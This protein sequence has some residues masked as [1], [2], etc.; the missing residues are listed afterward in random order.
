LTLARRRTLAGL[1]FVAPSTILIVVFFLIPVAMTAW[2]SLHDWPL[3]GAQEWLGLANYIDLLGDPVF[4]SAL[5]FTATYALMVTPLTLVVG[6]GLAQIVRQ[7]LGGMGLLRT[8]YFVPV[9]IGFAAASFIWY[10][11]LDPR[12]GILDAFLRGI[13]LTDGPTRF[14]GEPGTALGAAAVLF[15]WKFAGF[16]MLIFL[17]G[18]QAIPT[19]LY[20]A[21]A[22]DGASARQR[23]RFVTIPLLRRTFALVLVVTLIAALLAFDQ[24][25]VLTRGGPQDET[26]TVVYWIYKSGFQYMKLGYGS[27]IAVVLLL[28]LALMSV[29]QLVALR[30]EGD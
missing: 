18:M 17:I 5:R 3:L 30:G 26:L 7:P 27:A 24:F 4:W 28:G 15:V 12:V 16:S 29:I 1:A 6:F 2:M 25:F 9:V 22:V 21:A 14:L 23:M 8:A 20:E 19:P 11:M 13:G 10:W